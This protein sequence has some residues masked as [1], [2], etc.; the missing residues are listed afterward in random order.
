[1]SPPGRKEHDA[2]VRQVA[3]IEVVVLAVRE[4]L[5][6]SAVD[7]HFKE[8]IESVFRHVGLVHLVPLTGEVGIVPA[9]GKEHFS[10]VVGKHGTQEAARL[11]ERF[12]DAYG[13]RRITLEVF[14]DE[15]ASARPRP[16]AVILIGHMAEAA[17]H[18]L[19]EEDVVKVQQRIGKEF[20]ALCP[21]C[22]RVHLNLGP[23]LLR[24]AV[25]GPLGNTA[26]QGRLAE[27]EIFLRVARAEHFNLIQ[28]EVAGA[29]QL[30]PDEPR[31]LGFQLDNKR[32]L[33]CVTIESLAIVLVNGPP[34][35]AIIGEPEPQPAGA[36]GRAIAAIPDEH[37]CDGLFAA[38]VHL[39]PRFF[40]HPGMKRPFAVLD[41][42]DCA[43]C[44]HLGRNIHST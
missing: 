20:P 27:C 6:I 41:P 33:V 13:G 4:L 30:S 44:I 7:V 36:G 3:C 39:P 8:V 19:G 18:A 37:S 11:V 31:L 29:R 5:H 10:C 35:L 28:V 43:G 15:N 34:R 38:E 17:R 25:A 12:R 1:M 32:F 14:Q 16:P 21:L 22:F 26:L 40:F 9:P 42:V 23:R 24:Q 2:A